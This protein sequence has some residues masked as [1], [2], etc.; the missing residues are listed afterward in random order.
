MSMSERAVKWAKKLSGAVRKQRIDAQKPQMVKLEKEA[1]EHLVAI[2]LAVK[3]LIRGAPLLL[4]PYYIIFGK[5]IYRVLKTHSDETAQN[6]ICML[7]TK[8]Y[9]RGLDATLLNRL[10]AF[11]SAGKIHCITPLVPFRFDIS[12]LDGTDA[13][14]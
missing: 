1:T 5:E 14:T 3:Q 6:E 11:I 9:T 10:T 13:L 8:W 4:V 7:A 2:E 12:L